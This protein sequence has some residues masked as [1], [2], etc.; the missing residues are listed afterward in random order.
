M[1][2]MLRSVKRQDHVLPIKCL[3]SARQ[4]GETAM[5]VSPS[6][7]SGRVVAITMMSDRFRERIV[8]IPK[9]GIFFFILDFIIGK[10]CLRDR[11]PVDEIIAAVDQLRH[12]TFF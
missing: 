8:E 7:V 4:L 11:I 12:R 2:G 6:I 9:E 10:S 1:I 5:A 3:D